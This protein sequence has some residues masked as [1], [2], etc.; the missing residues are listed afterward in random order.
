[1]IDPDLQSIRR[2]RR[3]EKRCIAC[4]VRVPRAALCKACRRALRYCP[5]CDA[6]YPAAQA[7]SRATSGGQSAIYC[8]PCSNALRN[9]K[10]AR[11]TRPAYLQTMRATEH[12]QLRQI[13]R[14]YRQGL[15]YPQIA[16]AIGMCRGTLSATIAHA[17]KTGRWPKTLRRV[18]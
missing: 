9:G 6:V 18:L 5:G 4:G 3:Q 8:L 17:R 14:L 15:S 10:Q 1:M 2:K 7:S 11:V 13:K 12:P 16:D